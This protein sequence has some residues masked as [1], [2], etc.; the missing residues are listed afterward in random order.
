[1]PPD[2]R[3]QGQ[4]EGEPELLPEHGHAVAGVLIVG[5]VLILMAVMMIVHPRLLPLDAN[6]RRP[7]REVPAAFTLS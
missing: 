6:P 2:Q 3:R 5:L 1:M 4:E 7:K